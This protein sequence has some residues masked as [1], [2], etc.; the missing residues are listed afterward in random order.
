MTRTV[1]GLLTLA[2]GLAAGTAQA[3]TTVRRANGAPTPV[4]FGGSLGLS[5]PMGDAG[6]G[7]NTGFNIEGM[8]GIQPRS[9]PIEFRG[10]LMYHHFGIS[11]VNGHTS[12]LGI[13]PD[14]V[15][16][17]KT[18]S[19]LHPYV[20]GGLGLYHLSSS[21]GGGETDVGIN[22]GAG[23]RFPL[24]NAKTT[25]FVEARFHDVFTSGSS[26]NMIPIT[27]GLTF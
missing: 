26:F 2:L 14:V 16:P 21:V 1:A 17:F 24:S 20:I 19:S 9:M 22:F 10:E 7:L 3:Q 6:N 13:V 15:Y 23:L 4:T 5:M 8:V 11:G 27:V 18:Q 12:L 25:M